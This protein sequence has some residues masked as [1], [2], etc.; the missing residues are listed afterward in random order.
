MLTPSTPKSLSMLLT[1]SLGFW[2]SGAL[3][4]LAQGAG[5]T[6]VAVLPCGGELPRML[7]WH[8]DWHKCSLTKTKG[9]LA[10]LYNKP[11]LAYS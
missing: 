7:S 4:E 1:L 6:A 5:V 8:H 11:F 2:G 3:L 10:G 9:D